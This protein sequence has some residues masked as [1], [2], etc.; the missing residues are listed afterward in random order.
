MSTGEGVS[1][2]CALNFD[3]EAY[4]RHRRQPE[5]APLRIYITI[6]SIKG[7]VWLSSVGSWGG[8]CCSVAQRNDWKVLLAGANDGGGGREVEVAKDDA[9]QRVD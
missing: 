7:F 4:R 2:W 6:N 5:Q 9:Q 3:C 1:P 8:R